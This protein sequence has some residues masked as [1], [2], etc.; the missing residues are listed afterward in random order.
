[1]DPLVGTSHAAQTL[2]G[3]VMFAAISDAPVLLTGEQ[4][5]CKR[6]IS[7][8]IHARSS[9]SAGPLVH[10]AVHGFPDTLIASEIVGHVAG[11]FGGALRDKRGT[12][13]RADGGSLILSG[14]HTLGPLTARALTPLIDYG[15]LVPLGAAAPAR[16]VDVRILATASYLDTSFRTA[17]VGRGAL[18]INAPPLRTR[19]QDIGALAHDH[20]ASSLG[21]DIA[22]AD[23]ALDL[24]RGYHWPGNLREL[25][26]VIESAAAYRTRGVIG[27]DDLPRRL[28]Q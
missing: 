4:G 13:Q 22:V 21:M 8:A 1:M 14:L 25:A 20:L 12:V 26:Q 27:P 15:D 24:L 23:E 9:R 10:L 17:L 7:E 3:Q 5:V 18:E 2:L 6:V 11:A 16:R 19:L 28:W